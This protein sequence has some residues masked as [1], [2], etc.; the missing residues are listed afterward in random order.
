MPNADPRRYVTGDPEIDAA[1]ERL[2]EIATRRSGHPENAEFARQMVVSAARLL[3]DGA[4]R[5]EMKLLNAALKELRHAF[6]VFRPWR[7]VP[8]V[9]V[10]GSA[11]TPPSDPA[12]GLARRFAELIT[13]R[14]WMVITGAG[15]GI[16]GAAQ[17]GAGRE[18]SFGVNIRLPF[19]QR[20]NPVIADDPKLINFRYFFTRKVVF[21]KESHAILLLPGGLGTHDEAFEALTLVQTGKCQLLPIVFLDVPGGTYWRDLDGHIR[22]HL[23]ARGMMSPGDVHLYRVTD[24]LDVALREILGFY[25]NYHSS[26][27]VRDLFVFRVRRAPDEALLSRLNEDFADL[28]T[29]GRIEVRGAFPE[30]SDAREHP[31]VVLHADPRA[32]GRMRQLLDALNA[33][34]PEVQTPVAPLEPPHV[35]ALRVRASARRRA[36]RGGGGT[37]GAG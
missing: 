17:G 18:R 7:G 13:A 22:R 19:E 2:T 20:A 25:R 4:D 36:T 12:W 34:V 33:L 21:V 26:R 29:R 15:A 1:V 11:R 28:V 10:F 8:K 6:R 23:L 37:T 32:M 14:G 24:D 9:S 35:P 27:Y 3:L 31:R 16:M 30:E 5:G